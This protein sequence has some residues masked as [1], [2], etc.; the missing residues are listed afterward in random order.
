[1]GPNHLSQ[2][3]SGE[4]GGSIDDQLPNAHL[5]RV[6][7]V[8][9]YLEDIALFLTIGKCPDDYTPTE[10]HHMDVRGVNYQLIVG[11]L[12]KIGLDHILRRCIL[13]HEMDD[14]LWE[15]HV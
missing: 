2:L 11:Q 6:E 12:Y 15:Y 8:P 4:L 13:D 5:F 3:E 7:P 10:K 1:M 14:T 9:N